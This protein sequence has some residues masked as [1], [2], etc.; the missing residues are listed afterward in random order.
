MLGVIDQVCSKGLLLM[1]GGPKPTVALVVGS[2]HL[3]GKDPQSAG[4]RDWLCVAVALRG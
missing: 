3:P 4:C 1:P 2:A